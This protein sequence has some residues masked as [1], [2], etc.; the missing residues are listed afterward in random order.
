MGKHI[1]KT[2]HIF[3]PLISVI[4]VCVMYTGNTIIV[5]VEDTANTIEAEVHW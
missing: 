5:L 3:S 1:R 2:I 4:I